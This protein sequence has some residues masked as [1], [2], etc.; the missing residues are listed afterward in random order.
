MTYENSLAFAL[1]AD[2]DD[3]LNHFRNRFFIPESD[4]KSV[5]YF[6]GNSLGLQPKT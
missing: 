6:C 4:G 1:Q 3:T 2:A 5:I